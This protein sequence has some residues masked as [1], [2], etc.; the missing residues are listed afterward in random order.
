MLCV[1]DPLLVSTHMAA[2]AAASASLKVSTMGAAIEHEV[3][4]ARHWGMNAVFLEISCSGVPKSIDPVLLCELFVTRYN[5]APVWAW[6]HGL[7]E[8]L[9]ELNFKARSLLG[10]ESLPWE[11]TFKAGL[12]VSPGV[13]GRWAQGS[14]ETRLHGSKNLE[15][16]GCFYIIGWCAG[17]HRGTVLWD[18]C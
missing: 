13:S 12:V 2:L 4:R 18:L 15:R 1:T 3:W 16:T 6:R 9:T 7:R 5:E 14:S 10:F 8:W 11:P 17:N